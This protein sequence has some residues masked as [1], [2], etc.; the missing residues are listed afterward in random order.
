[1]PERTGYGINKQLSDQFRN[2]GSN[3]A[4]YLPD[5]GKNFHSLLCFCV[6]KTGYCYE[7]RSCWERVGKDTRVFRKE[8]CLL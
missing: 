5:F 6:F 8:A 2:L 7:T 4:S 3:L 1:M